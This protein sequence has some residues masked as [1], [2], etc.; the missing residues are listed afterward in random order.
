MSLGLPDALLAKTMLDHLFQPCP[1]LP[2]YIFT[3]GVPGG[4]LVPGPYM[5]H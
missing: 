1:P 4:S 5:L 3:F 2:E